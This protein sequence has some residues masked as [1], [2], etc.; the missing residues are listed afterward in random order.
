MPYNPIRKRWGSVA[1]R[2]LHDD[3]PLVVEDLPYRLAREIHAR[4]VRD[5]VSTCICP[6]DIDTAWG[7]LSNGVGEWLDKAHV[8]INIYEQLRDLVK[9]DL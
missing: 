9:E 8:L 7:K 5:E 6:Q 3:T 2:D 1:Y 4:H